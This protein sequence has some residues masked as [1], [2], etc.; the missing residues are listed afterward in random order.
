MASNRTLVYLV[1]DDEMYLKTA[2][3][4]LSQ[5][6]ALDI[7]SFTGGE[8]ALK[9]A[10]SASKQPDIFVLDYFLNSDNP[11][12]TSGLEILK[13]LRAKKIDSDV[14]MLSGQENID[15]AVNS[16]KYGAF[17]YVV[18]NKSAFIRVQNDIKRISKSRIK[19]KENKKLKKFIF[20]L[21][22]VLG[23]LATLSII[24]FM[25]NTFF[26]LLGQ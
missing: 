26:G 1:D 21:I 20:A 9:A 19:D 14:I 11:E 23:I 25:D 24:F 5:N 7:V 15:V 8:E 18:K 13:K 3:H 16:V 17:D 10:E 22:V 2:L 6:R 4:N 12:A